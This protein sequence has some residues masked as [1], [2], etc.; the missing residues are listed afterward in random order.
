MHHFKE[1][2]VWQ[3]SINLATDIYDLTTQ[4]PKQETY[5]LTS[6]IRKS[7]ISIS[8]NIA[9]GAGRFSKKEFRHFLNIAYGSAFELETQLIISK[10]L[11]YVDDDTFEPL[12]NKITDI[13]KMLYKLIES[14]V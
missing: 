3:K 7:A 5:G 2:N 14:I 1:L 8:S 12:N 6:Q 11:K 10:N 4:Y 9:E 13:Q